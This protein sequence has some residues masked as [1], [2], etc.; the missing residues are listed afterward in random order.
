[1]SAHDSS[2]F[3]SIFIWCVFAI[4][5]EI[6]AKTA[7]A[8]KEAEARHSRGLHIF[9]V[10]A[11][12]LLLFCPGFGIYSFVGLQRRFLPDS[13][14]PLAAGLTLNLLGLV[15]AVW[16]RRCL[17]RHWS[18]EITIK[19]D[20]QLIR[21]GPYRLVRHPIYTA[22]LC[23]YLGTAIVSGELH[24]LVGALLGIGAYLRKIRMEEANLVR[25]FG[26]EYEEY[27]QQTWAVVP[28][29]I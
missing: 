28:G 8:V 16:A 18:G 14:L 24:A 10:S 19:V 9:L 23:L 22:M 17:G 6:A 15:L 12:Q 1:M 27:R 26:A 5:W 29:L 11:S 21:T 3:A 7:S 20:H 2:I 13:T 4:Y 25:A